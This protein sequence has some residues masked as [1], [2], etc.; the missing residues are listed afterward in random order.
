VEVATWETERGQEDRL[1]GRVMDGSGSELCPVEDFDIGS[2]E[3]SGPATREL[4]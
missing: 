3:I 1:W 4:A 2:I